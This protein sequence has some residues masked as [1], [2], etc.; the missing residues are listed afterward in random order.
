MLYEVL[1]NEARLEV[2]V[3]MMLLFLCVVVERFDELGLCESICARFFFFSNHLDV[4]YFVLRLL[5]A[6]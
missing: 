6:G 4:E 1:A 3:D 5:F 2:P